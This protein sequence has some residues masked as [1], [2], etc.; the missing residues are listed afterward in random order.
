MWQYEGTHRPEFAETPG[1]GQESV[2]DYPR[3]PRIVSD[4]RRVVVLA[5]ELV[6]AE[7]TQSQRV[8]ETASPPT[9]YLQPDHIDLNLLAPASGTSSCE[10][11]G[12]ATSVALNLPGRSGEAVGWSYRSPRPVFTAIAGWLSFY[13]GRVECFIDG[14]RVRPQPG[15]FY[16]GW[17]TSE[18]VGPVKGLLGTGHW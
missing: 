15:G 12:L 1:P 2:W 10:W 3:P 17:V 5:G 16:G 6:I 18:I 13:P 4:P 11:K 14:E 9:F 7:S 8:L